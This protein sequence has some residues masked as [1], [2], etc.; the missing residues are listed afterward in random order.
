LFPT[1]QTAGDR[2][3]STADRNVLYRLA[4][5][6][7]FNDFGVYAGHDHSVTAAPDVLAGS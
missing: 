6:F 1:G 4:K 2:W 5:R 7:G 3:Q